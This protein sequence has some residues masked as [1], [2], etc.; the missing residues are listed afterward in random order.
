MSQSP[1]ES[2]MENLVAAAPG[3]KPLYDEHLADYDELLPHVFLGDVARFLTLGFAVEESTR[4]QRSQHGDATEALRILEEVVATKDPDMLE[5]VSVSLLE[6]I[7]WA[8]PE[9]RSIRSAMGPRLCEE[10]SRREGQ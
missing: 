7:I 9:G 10:I 3:L 6:N 4:L 8:S 2:W 5:L 1:V